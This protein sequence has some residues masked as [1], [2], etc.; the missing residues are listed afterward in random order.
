MVI[1]ILL[2]FVFSEFVIAIIIINYN[3]YRD[4]IITKT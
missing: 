1:I 2:F 4:S 3:Y